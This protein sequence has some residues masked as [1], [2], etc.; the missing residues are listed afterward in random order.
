MQAILIAYSSSGENSWLGWL[1]LAAILP[2]VAFG[3][4]G[5]MRAWLRARRIKRRSGHQISSP[6]TCRWDGLAHRRTSGS[7]GS[8]IESRTAC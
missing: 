3:L 7:G 8:L 4:V 1:I 6:R 5:M 2:F